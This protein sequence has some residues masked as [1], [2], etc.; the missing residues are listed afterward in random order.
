MLETPSAYAGRD[1]KRAMEGLTTW[2]ASLATCGVVVSNRHCGRLDSCEAFV[3]HLES[4]DENLEAI[5]SVFSTWTCS[6][7][8]S[9][10]QSQLIICQVPLA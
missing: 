6:I 2:R 1:R 3:T 9:N 7:P 4:R 5:S 8:I 10:L